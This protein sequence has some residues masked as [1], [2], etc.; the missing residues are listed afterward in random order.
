MKNIDKPATPRKTRTPEKRVRPR[1]NDRTAAAEEK[2]QERK[3]LLEMA[4]AFLESADRAYCIDDYALN[5]T[6]LF[7]YRMLWEY[8]RDILGPRDYLDFC[9]TQLTAWEDLYM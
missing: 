5:E 6:Y 4:A 8:A 2:S 7:L 9:K 3:R 1:N